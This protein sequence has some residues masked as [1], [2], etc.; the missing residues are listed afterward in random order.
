MTKNKKESK[1]YQE[2]NRG[3]RENS[4]ESA[5]ST[6]FITCHYCKKNRPQSKGLQKNGEIV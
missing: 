3:G 4:R 5:M 1:R 2:L 6:A